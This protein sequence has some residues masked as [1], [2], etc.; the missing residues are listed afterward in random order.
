MAEQKPKKAFLKKGA[1]P[2]LSNAQVRSLNQKP[3]IV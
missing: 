2:F 3:R 1:R